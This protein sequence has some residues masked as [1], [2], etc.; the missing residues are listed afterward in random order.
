MNNY[1][2][3]EQPATPLT[4]AQHALWRQLT[5]DLTPAQAA[6][7]SGYYA[8]LGT[9]APLQSAS[10]ASSA[11]Q[12]IAILVGSQT[13]NGDKLA[14][15]T[16]DR[17][18]AR[19]LHATIKRLD[20]YKPNQ[21]KNEQDLLL[22]ISTHGEG[23]P[24]D[25]AKDLYEYIHS[26]RAPKLLNTRFAVLALGDSSY[27]HFCK[28]GKDFDQ[29]FEEL[30]ASRLSPRVDCDVD[31]EDP[32]ENWMDTVLTTLAERASTTSTAP[33][34][35]TF[36]FS[37]SLAPATPY[38]RRHPFPA[39][40]LEDQILNGRGSRKETHHLELSLEGSGLTYEPGDSL[41]IYPVNPPAAVD[42]LLQAGAW[43]GDEPIERNEQTSPL[44]TVLLEQTEITIITRTVL[45]AYAALADHA[46]LNTLLQESHADQLSTYL[47]GRDLAD[48]LTDY[49]ISGLNP[50]TFVDLLRNLPPRLYSIASSLKQHPDE[51]HLTVAAVRY[52]SYGRDRH[53]VCSTYLADRIA[54]DATLPVYI[55]ENRHFRLP[56]DPDTPIIMI[57]PG[58]GV[59]P[60]RAFIEERE[61]IG[62]SG[63][64]WLFFGDQH[65][66]TDF[67]Y[68]TEWQQHLKRGLLTRISV[69]FSRDQKEKC[70]VQHRMLEQSRALYEWLHDGATLYVCGDA[71]RMAPDVHEAL[72]H[73]LMQEGDH[74]REH[75]EAT[76]KTMQQEKRY[77]RDV[78]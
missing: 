31:F 23:D 26:K 15:Q 57:G 51:A 17:A 70:Y 62:A 6:W 24:P 5:T 64:N 8:A 43:T 3:P 78:Y 10:P 11:T 39:T 27:E 77:L 63:R 60:F 47:H 54:P 32:A 44:R 14:E 19:G 33:T 20:D 41:G 49:P 50:Q 25:N 40:I 53:G 69:A 42:A 56:T 76:I 37:P 34:T 73:I 28:T 7:L 66:T 35:N 48:L 9:A 30:G 18:T 4:P 1:I 12:E 45:K 55:H 68:Q 75:A 29:R 71:E 74:N 67:L 46:A 21:L 58:T 38:S 72:I 59:A 65:F 13:G 61:A 22:I 2:V 52:H 36:A 16:L